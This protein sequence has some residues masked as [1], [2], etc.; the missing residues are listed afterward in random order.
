[1]QADNPIL[2]TK[3]IF[4]VFILLVLV[5][6]AIILGRGLFVPDSWGLY[7]GF[8]G[9]NVEQ[10]R[11]KAVHHG[12]DASCQKCHEEE[13]DTHEGGGH[14]AVRCE[15]CHGPVS[16]HVSGDKKI[17]AMPMNRGRDLCLRCHRKLE[18]RPATFPQVEPRAHV[19]EN[20][21]DWGDEACIECHIPHAPL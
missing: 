3:H 19:D 21:G 16:I 4:R 10:Q 8:R 5:V 9:D 11:A 7:G 2:H 13:F 18:A 12:G 6:I 15:V 1:M 20:G 14:A 17:A